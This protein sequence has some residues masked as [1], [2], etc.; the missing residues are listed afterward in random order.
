[1]PA[2][3]TPARAGG[4]RATCTKE[5]RTDGGRAAG[6]VGELGAA[7][8]AIGARPR[9][10]GA[11]AEG[12]PL[13]ERVE[14]GPPEEGA[15]AAEEVDGW[16]IRPVVPDCCRSGKRNLEEAERA[17]CLHQALLSS[18]RFQSNGWNNF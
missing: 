2:A 18:V 9:V 6:G 8:R 5:S 7:A 10:E 4:G 16:P 3:D 1:M 13:V 11:P 14:G 12:A 15:P 17:A